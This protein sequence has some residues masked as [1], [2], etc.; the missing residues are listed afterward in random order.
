VIGLLL[1]AGVTYVLAGQSQTRTTTLTK[2]STVVS[3]T[4][5]VSTTTVLSNFT[6]T[7][8][9]VVPVYNEPETASTTNSSIGLRLALTTNAT[10]LTVGQS[11]QVG[12]SLFNTLSSVNTVPISLQDSNGL[13][14]SGLPVALWSPCF[15]PGS[16]AQAALLQGNYTLQ[17]LPVV[18]NYSYSYNCTVE[19]TLDHVIFAPYSSKANFTGIYSESVPVSKPV[20][21]GPYQL[22][23]NFTTNGYWSLLNNS[24]LDSGPIIGLQ[25]GEGCCQPTATAFAPGVYTLAVE[26]EWGQTLVQHFTVVAATSG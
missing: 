5:A 26:D 12:I 11:L 13:D 1:G 6:S 24:G 25:E 21:G 3:T 18:A 17:E 10:Y 22:S 7:S 23:V 14:F 15:I 4:S 9:K 2:T 20:P 19:T 8:T 16:G